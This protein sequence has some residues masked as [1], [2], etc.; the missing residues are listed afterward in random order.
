MQEYQGEKRAFI[1]HLPSVTLYKEQ[2]R[3]S[4]DRVV[5]KPAVAVTPDQSIVNPPAPPVATPTATVFGQ[6]KSTTSE[7]FAYLAD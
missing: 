3:V 4:S 6:S 2:M 7:T 5:A 1:A